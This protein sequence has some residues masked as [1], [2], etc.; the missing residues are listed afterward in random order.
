MFFLLNCKYTREHPKYIYIL[1]E[2]ERFELYILSVFTR[3]NG[4]L[5]AFLQRKCFFY[6]FLSH[7]VP[8]VMFNLSRLL[9]VRLRDMWV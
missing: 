6:A 3:E 9:A 5:T 4:F 2:K 1:A 7:T 8:I